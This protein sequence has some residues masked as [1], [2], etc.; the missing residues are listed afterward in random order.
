MQNTYEINTFIS[1]FHLGASEGSVDLLPSPSDATSWTKDLPTDDGHMSDRIFGF[2]GKVNAV[3]VPMGQFN[4]HLKEH[5]TMAT[6]MKHERADV[7]NHSH[8]HPAK[9]HILCMSDAK[10]KN[11]Q[12]IYEANFSFEV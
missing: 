3:E 11:I 5:F 7:D 2:D 10:G 9:E 4:H 8:H 1:P 12:S 6:W